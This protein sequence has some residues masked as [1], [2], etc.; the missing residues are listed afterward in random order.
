[1]NFGQL[2]DNLLKELVVKVPEV[3]VLV[4]EKKEEPKNEEVESEEKEKEPQAEKPEEN[5]EVA[6]EAKPEEEN[7][8]EADEAPKEETPMEEDA[9]AEEETPKEDDAAKEN[10]D[11]ETKEVVEEEE[12]AK[13]PEPVKEINR[14]NLPDYEFIGRVAKENLVAGPVRPESRKECE[15]V[16]MIGLPG[17]GKTHW[18]LKYVSENPEKRYDILGDSA[19][20]GRMKV[21]LN[22][23]AEIRFLSHCYCCLCLEL[24]SEKKGPNFA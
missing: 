1:M 15:V 13:E 5:V 12:L 16:L 7:K 14:E 21:S 19:L 6:E 11:D 20:I 24:F 17:A 4:K 22:R 18:A 9:K 2:E 8:V 23:I 3:V 10:N